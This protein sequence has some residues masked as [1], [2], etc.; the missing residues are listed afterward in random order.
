ML[1]EKGRVRKR[2]RAGGGTLRPE[3]R[4]RPRFVGSPGGRRC[5]SAI[6]VLGCP[7]SRQG[8]E[9]EVATGEPPPVIERLGSQAVAGT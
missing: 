4:T 5:P 9:A 3:D 1:T 8:V 6:A 2:A 7:Q